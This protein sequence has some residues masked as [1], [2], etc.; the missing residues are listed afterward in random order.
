MKSIFKY[1]LGLFSFSALL[2]TT[3]AAQAIFIRGNGGFA[4]QVENS[5]Y[6]YDAYE[7]V[8][9][10]PQAHLNYSK[11]LTVEGK[12]REYISRMP[13][14]LNTNVIY[15]IYDS[16]NSHLKE[17]RIED[18][19]RPDVQYTFYETFSELSEEVPYPFTIA[20][21]NF[22]NALTQDYSV[23]VASY[24][25]LSDDQK[26]VLIFHEVIYIYL[27]KMDSFEPSP[28]DVRRTVQEILVR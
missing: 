2:L 7:L 10:D 26:A 27:E 11:A 3:S 28:E 4:V 23:C 6:A 5:W 20:A 22:F 16:M 18:F 24:L 19:N 25:H 15:D 12:V 17:C 8:I 14:P 21:I 13:I 1:F 9:K